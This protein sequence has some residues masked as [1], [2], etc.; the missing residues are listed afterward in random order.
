MSTAPTQGNP[1]LHQRV[2]AEIRA[3]MARHRMTQ[4]E[5]A[6]QLGW[7]QQFLSRRLTGVVPM[8][9]SELGALADAFD[10]D[11][12]EFLQEPREPRVRKVPLRRI[13]RTA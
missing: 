6:H 7:K 2:A 13:L 8:D 10:V 11:P 3:Y 4:S 5:L 1:P 12:S 9:L